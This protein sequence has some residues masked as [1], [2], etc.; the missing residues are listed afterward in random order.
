MIGQYVGF[1]SATDAPTV[2]EQQQREQQQADRREK[3]AQARER[4]QAKAEAAQDQTDREE[5][6]ATAVD[7]WIGL[8]DETK[9]AISAMVKQFGQEQ[10]PPA[11]QTPATVTAPATKTAPQ[12]KAPANTQ[13]PEGQAPDWELGDEELSEI[14]TYLSPKTASALR[15]QQALLRQAQNF[16]E[17]ATPILEAYAQERN[18]RVRSQVAKYEGAAEKFIAGLRT[19]GVKAFDTPEGRQ[20]LL[21]VAAH[22][23]T[24]ALARDEGKLETAFRLAANS[25]APDEVQKAIEKRALDAVESK[26]A[27]RQ[28][29]I[30]R[31]VSGRGTQRARTTKQGDEAALDVVTAWSQTR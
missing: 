18:D 30:D 3:A 4:A 7:Q 24:G 23:W 14:E 25:L 13:P 28:R 31:G 10:T 8:D 5:S 21:R 16:I 22:F 9:G 27:D 2:G 15:G 19:D 26:A 29:L 12:P 11:Q 20:Q 17:R 1:E 6:S